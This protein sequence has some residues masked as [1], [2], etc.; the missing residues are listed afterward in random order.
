MYTFSILRLE[1]TV[2]IIICLN[3][4][5]FCQLEAPGSAPYDVKAKAVSE[6]T[7]FVQWKP[8]IQPNGD[9]EVRTKN[10]ICSI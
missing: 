4:L 6:T 2:S 10:F 8:P 9:I 5:T 3:V 7:A 1:I